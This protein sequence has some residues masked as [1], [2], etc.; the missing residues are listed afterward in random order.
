MHDMAVA[1]RNGALAPLAVTPHL[2][3]RMCPLNRHQRVANSLYFYQTLM[4]SM[5]KVSIE[6]CTL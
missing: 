5:M 2:W 3:T 6:Y 4:M 1:P